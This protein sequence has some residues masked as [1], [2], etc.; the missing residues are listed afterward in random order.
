[1]L[2]AL[3]PPSEKERAERRRKRVQVCTKHSRGDIDCLRLCLGRLGWVEKP[4]GAE[5]ADIFWFSR[6][7]DDVRGGVLLRTLLQSPHQR[8]S[9]LEGMRAM[10]HKDALERCLERLRALYPD[11][12]G[13]APRTY[14]LPEAYDRFSAALEASRRKAPADGPDTF[15][16]KPNGGSEGHGI[17]LA[18][19][20]DD[21]PPGV[22]RA[23]GLG[24]VAQEYIARPLLLD[25]FKFDLRLY[26]LVCSVDPPRA[27]VCREGLVRLCSEPYAEPAR[28]NLRNVFAHL[29]NSSLNKHHDEYVL[30][31]AGE[32]DGSKR[33]LSEA[34]DGGLVD[35]ERQFWAQ[36]RDMTAL[37]L[38]AMQPTLAL[39]YRQRFPRRR[40]G[41]APS[42][43]GRACAAD[44]EEDDAE[45]EAE[46]EDEGGDD[47]EEGDDSFRCFHILGFD[48][49]LDEDGK[50]HLL[51]VNANPAMSITREVELEDDR[52]SGGFCGA[53]APVVTELSRVDER[54]KTTVVADAL[55]LVLHRGR[56]PAD[57]DDDAL[58]SYLPVLTRST[59]PAYAHFQLPRRVGRVYERFAGALHARSLAATGGV[60]S[61]AFRRVAAIVG[62]SGRVAE[63]IFTAL[64]SRHGVTHGRRLDLELFSRALVALARD[65]A[66]ALGV[67][68][69]TADARAPLEAA[70]SKLLD[71]DACDEP[72]PAR[73]PGRRQKSGALPLTP[74][75]AGGDSRGL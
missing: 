4:K 29:T 59:E 58:R 46:D 11:A 62:A 27:Y 61:A 56:L 21:M 30:D 73:A 69:A 43:G 17:F 38:I 75:L 47:D 39:L 22:A 42:A 49:L 34:L 19:T 53:A 35:D 18:Q 2:P 40:A 71:A 52:R 20:A 23:F 8:G 32:G 50:P 15:I 48:V 37:T 74:P 25:G 33:R 64:C 31:D 28:G 68:L 63:R 66:P 70:V 55:R 6:G 72:P 13:F 44:A 36:I 14:R 5:R 26:V 60:S 57:D 9:R 45:A 10:T 12:L 7:L 65:A 3:K 16:L 54:V 67:D 51:E 24:F 1:M 41:A